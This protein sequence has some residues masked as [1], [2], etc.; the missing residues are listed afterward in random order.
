M[1]TVEQLIQWLYTQD[2]NKTVLVMREYDC[3][4]YMGYTTEMVDLVLPKD[5]DFGY[6]P[7]IDVFNTSIWF[8]ERG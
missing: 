7:N 2:P 3:G 8:G 1:T 6:S 5:G 4:G